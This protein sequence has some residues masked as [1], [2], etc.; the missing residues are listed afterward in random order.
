MAAS[1][2]TGRRYGRR[3]FVS[4]EACY[5][6]ITF[7]G[8]RTKILCVSWYPFICNIGVTFPGNAALPLTEEDMAIDWS[9]YERIDDAAY[10]ENSGDSSEVD[11]LMD[12][13]WNWVRGLGYEMT[14]DEDG[15][16]V[17]YFA[18]IGLPKPDKPLDEKTQARLEKRFLKKY[19]GRN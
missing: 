11:Y 6:C 13:F 4:K 8:R 3:G 15:N 18:G 12:D 1:D 19:K 9:R 17:P 16:R 10:W 5:F 14:T 2:G 7:R